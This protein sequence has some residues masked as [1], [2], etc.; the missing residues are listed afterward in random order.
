MDCKKLTLSSPSF[1]EMLRSIPSA[2][3]QLYTTAA[4]LPE[5]LAKP[6]VA[7]IGSRN[8]TPYGKE[9]TLRLSEEL[10]RQGVVIVS[11]LALGVDS[12]AHQAALD[13]GGTTIAVLPGPIEKIYPASHFHLAMQIVK[14][15]GAL[16]SEYPAGTPIFKQNFIARN[17]LIA[18]LADAVLITE[19]AE[20]SGSLHTARFALEQG[21]DV[22]AVP[23]NITSPNSVGA[24][25]L[26]KAGAF[27]VTG[28]DDVLRIIGIEPAE[29]RE[30]KG[31]TAE[32]DLLLGLLQDGITDGEEL[33]ARSGL[34]VPVFNQTLT[35]LE[36]S[37]KIR[38]LGANRWS[39]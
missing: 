38:S 8:V 32:E 23:G 27:P 2:P 31:R 24:N 3:K 29:P 1:P 17:R 18:G 34:A 26:I 20:K 39:C 10:A 37:G 33:L 35:M 9:V 36:I 5:L 12:L 15:G 25:N 28:P 14:Q 11:G 6:R 4:N 13:A 22:L 21:R 16:I 30:V 19:A 7:I